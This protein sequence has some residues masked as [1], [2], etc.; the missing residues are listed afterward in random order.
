MKQR[1]VQS[2]AGCT[3]RVR[4]GVYELAEP[5]R[6]DDWTSATP[7]VIEAEK[8]ELPIISGGERLTDWKERAPGRWEVTLP[9]VAKGERNFQQLY[10][11]DERRMRPR[12]PQ[13]GYFH[14]EREV[15]A[16]P[17]AKDKGFDRIGFRAGDVRAD[18][19]NRGELE[20]LGFQI[21]TMTR[22]HIQDID[23]TQRNITFTGRTRGASWSNRWL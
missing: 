8:N 11:D 23:N 19:A 4:G 17:K 14:I 20:V 18:W 22:Q 1:A 15:E 7:L 3:I 16:S 13:S 9:Q 6:F 21:W 2:P 5:L 12:A 10:F